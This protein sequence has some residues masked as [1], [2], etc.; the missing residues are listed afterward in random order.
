MGSTKVVLA[1]SEAPVESE[2]D[3]DDD[4]KYL[5]DLSPSGLRCEPVYHLLYRP[6]HDSRGYEDGEN[7]HEDWVLP[8][9]LFASGHVLFRLADPQGLHNVTGA[10]HARSRLRRYIEAFDWQHHQRSRRTLRLP[11]LRRFATAVDTGVWGA[12]A[13]SSAV[14]WGEQRRGHGNYAPR[15]WL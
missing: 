5:D 10:V 2:G 9:V 3:N 7:R 1:F 8:S 4:A 6:N 11:W 13:G 15:G 12:T 14:R